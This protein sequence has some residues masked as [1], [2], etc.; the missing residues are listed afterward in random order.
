MRNAYTILVGKSA[1]NRPLGRPKDRWEGFLKWMSDICDACGWIS[2]KWL[3]MG[4]NEQ[5]AYVG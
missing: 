2:L 1:V 4:H 5:S 3:R